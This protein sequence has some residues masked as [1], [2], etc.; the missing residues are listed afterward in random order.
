MKNGEQAIS[1]LTD[2]LGGEKF[3]YCM[4][5]L[6]VRDID[7]YLDYLF[8]DKEKQIK[9]L[10]NTPVAS[11]FNPQSNDTIRN[12]K[13]DEIS[14]LTHTEIYY[15][16]ESF[17]V[18]IPLYLYRSVI[19][20]ILVEPLNGKLIDQSQLNEKIGGVELTVD[21]LS[22]I[23]EKEEANIEHYQDITHQLVGPLSGVRAHCENLL[24]GRVSVERGKVILETLVEQAGL[25]QRTAINFSYVARYHGDDIFRSTDWDPEL[26]THKQLVEILIKSTKSFQGQAKVMGIRGPSVDEISF[27]NFP[28][29]KLIPEL[30][31]I[32][33]LNL[34]DNAIKYSFDNSPITV[35]GLVSEEYVEI[36]FT[37]HGISLA[38]DE[39]I[40]IFKRHTRSK[41]AMEFSP[42]GSGIGL[43]L[44][45]QICKLHG[46]TIRALPSK[47]S[48]Y[49]NEVK[50]IIR[51]PNA[52]EKSND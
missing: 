10:F 28:M 35:V 23:L 41:S 46:W 52:N 17:V 42:G 29:L 37:N 19:A 3:L 24:R 1:I 2:A 33:V 47:R 5:S 43:F 51:I 39:I 7:C 4:L 13:L 21:I 12:G 40:T 32:L 20:V 27:K 49:G 22:H 45:D 15:F 30:F 8:L 34:C 9:F 16:D 11:Y 50:F 48:T 26:V 36:E 14:K 31:E 18:A 38:E 25:L 6:S 44:C